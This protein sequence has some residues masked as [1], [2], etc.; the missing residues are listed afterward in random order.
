LTHFVLRIIKVEFDNLK[1]M[2]A[3]ISAPD[4][5]TRCPVC[6]GGTSVERVRCGDCGTAVEGRFGLGWPGQLEAEQLAFVRVFLEC[7]GKIKDVEQALGLSYPTVVARLDEVVE[8]IQS[9]RRPPPR[10]RPPARPP[11]YTPPP[12]DDRQR[13]QILDDLASGLIDVEEAARRLRGS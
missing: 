13:Q 6:G 11:P 4:L 3:E 5:L 9:G 10:I 7:R 8:A 1:F 2:S 12:A